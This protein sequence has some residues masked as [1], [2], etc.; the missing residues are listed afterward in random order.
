LPYNALASRLDYG[1]MLTTDR[2]IIKEDVS[3]RHHNTLRL[4]IHCKYFVNITSIGQL[5]RLIDDRILKENRFL[6]LGRGSNIFFLKN[7]DGLVLKISIK[8]KELLSE[9]NKNVIIQANAG[10]DWSEL[11]EFAV[12]NGW[13][14]I[15]N[16]A[17]IPGSVGAAPVQNIACYGHNLHDSLLSLDAIDVNSGKI[18]KF[19]NEDCC[20]G[21]RDSIF[22][23][24]L[25][26]KVIIIRIRLKLN[27]DPILNTWYKS[28]YES[29]AEELTKVACSKYTI[30]D[31]YQAIINI[32][33]RKMPDIS[34][35]GSAGSF[36][37]NPIITGA[38]FQEIK[39]ICPDIHCYPERH[40]CYD[41]VPVIDTETKVKIPAAWL[42]EEIGWAGKRVG[43]CGTWPTQ[44]LSIVNYGNANS[45]ELLKF[46]NIVKDKVNEAFGIQLQNEVELV[47]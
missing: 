47:C 6:V 31:V 10:E 19:V 5:T 33:K 27:K 42:L 12:H 40:L 3:L 21:Y 37:K 36:F 2:Y 26:G 35:V 23:N 43:D 8:G 4:D 16:L 17:M 22:K 44:P 9:D 13:G 1:Q 24:E 25:K 28:R 29:I 15:E 7:F 34:K 46:V 14:G 38:R 32:R 45:E 11:V 30:A 41:T 18:H 39:S 20:F